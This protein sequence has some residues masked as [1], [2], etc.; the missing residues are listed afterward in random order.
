VFSKGIFV[1]VLNFDKDEKLKKVRKYERPKKYVTKVTVQPLS[2]S[3]F[4]NIKII[5]PKEYDTRKYN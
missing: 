1:K 4:C 2:L 5:N 3:Y